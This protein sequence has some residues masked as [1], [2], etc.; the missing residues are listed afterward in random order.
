[1]RAAFYSEQGPAA[2]VFRIGDQP[3]PEPGPG[4]VRVRLRTSGVN[5][6]EWKVR[7]GGFGRGL[8]API[9][10]PH[11]DG[12]GVIDAVGAAV[13]DRKIGERV[14][15]WNGQ[16]RRAFGTAAEYI[17]VPN[18]TTTAACSACPAR[19]APLRARPRQRSRSIHT[20]WQAQPSRRGSC[21]ALIAAGPTRRRLAAPPK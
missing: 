18:E 6:S 7:K 5:P 1:M 20:R 19:S 16:W 3:T 21:A 11:S 10:I 4:E 9:V 17:S 8:V 2:A 12:A 13:S 14:W 15:I